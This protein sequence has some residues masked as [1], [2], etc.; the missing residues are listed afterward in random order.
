[1]KNIIKGSTLFI[2]AAIIGYSLYP[3]INKQETLSELTAVNI[4]SKDSQ[5]EIIEGDKD[6]GYQI[7]SKSVDHEKVVKTQN[8]ASSQIPVNE[9]QITLGK[10]TKK[11]ITNNPD[12]INELAEWSYTHK[13]SIHKVIEDNM[14]SSII[15]SIKSSIAKENK[16]FENIDVKQSSADDE[17]WAYIM[18]QKIRTYLSQHEL[19]ASF[20]LLNVSCKQLICDI[21]GIQRD[22]KNW[23]QIHRGLYSLP[24]VKYPTDGNRP[25]NVIRMLKD[26]IYIYSQI[27]FNSSNI[28]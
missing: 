19:S 11:I 3:V 5:L 27:M 16:L 25:I 24:N 12:I 9:A 28:N 18:E 17:Q 23:V 20:D 15:S 8:E 1:M 22:S 13:E 21:V 4:S 7:P 14:P 6:S 26:N 10:N 2:A